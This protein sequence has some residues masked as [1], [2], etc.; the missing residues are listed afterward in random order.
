V[1]VAGALLLADRDA[2]AWWRIERARVPG[3]DLPDIQALR[4]LRSALSATIEAL[5]ADR[6]VSRVAVSDLN[7]I[8]QSAPA[9]TRLLLTLAAVDRTD[10]AHR[11]AFFKSPGPVAVRPGGGIGPLDHGL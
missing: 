7:F 2:E 5:V 10:R 9:S 8:M 4:Q 6:S 3:G 11:F 1:C